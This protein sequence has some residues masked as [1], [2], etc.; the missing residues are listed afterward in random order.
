[1]HKFHSGQAVEVFSYSENR[2]F[3]ATVI[4]CIGSDNQGY[5]YEL[6]SPC[7][8]KAG[9]ASYSF[10]TYFKRVNS[11]PQGQ[12]FFGN[13]TTGNIVAIEPNIRKLDKP[14]TV[15]FHTMINDLKQERPFVGDNKT[16]TTYVTRDDKLFKWWSKER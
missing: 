16:Y 5:W 11:F 9:V 8:T 7:P 14:K 13:C 1:M 4:N 3:P 6:F 12:E 10:I 15:D 2:W